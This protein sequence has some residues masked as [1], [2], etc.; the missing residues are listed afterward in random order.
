MKSNDPCDQAP[1]D[2]EAAV[3]TTPDDVRALE[4]L[5]RETPSW[6]DLPPHVVEA[7]LPPGA[8]DRR[9][10]MSPAARPFEL[11]TEH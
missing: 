11:D 1:L 6:L 8:L 4:R 5:R 3:P 2:L 9:P 7:L 10:P